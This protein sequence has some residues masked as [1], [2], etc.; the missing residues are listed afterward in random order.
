MKNIEI[1]E[2][3]FWRIYNALRDCENILWECDGATN[4]E[5]ESL[6][7]SIN[8]CAEETSSVLLKMHD[9]ILKNKLDVNN[10]V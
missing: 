9:M 8:G 1:N 5:N 4:P 7:E 3:F 10:A 6:T 2:T